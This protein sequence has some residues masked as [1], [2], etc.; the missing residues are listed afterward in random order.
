MC[1]ISC[2]LRCASLVIDW[3]NYGYTILGWF[4]FF[5][6]AVD[7]LNFELVFHSSRRYIAWAFS[8]AR[9]PSGGV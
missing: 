6:L 2:L 1:Q 9:S 8:L 4:D 5:N 3:H 7:A